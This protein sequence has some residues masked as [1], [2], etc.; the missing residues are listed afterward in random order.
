MAQNTNQSGPSPE[1]QMQQT[2]KASHG[3]AMQAAKSHS[4]GLAKMMEAIQGLHSQ[5]MSAQAAPPAGAMMPGQDQGGGDPEQ[6]VWS[7]F[8][9]TD[10]S[11]VDRMIQQAGSL[12]A[13]FPALAHMLEQDHQSLT[14]KWLEAVSQRLGQPAGQPDTGAAP[15]NPGVGGEATAY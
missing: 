14:D 9:S 4:D 5:T 13:A 7:A 15:Q 10:P 3:V 11:S 12:E 2:L 8:P 6:A 1:Q